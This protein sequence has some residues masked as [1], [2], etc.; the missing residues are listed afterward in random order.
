[1]IFTIKFTWWFIKM[2]FYTGL[3]AFFL[4]FVLPVIALLAMY[5]EDVR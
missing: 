5:E 1:M 2:L 3:M 4:A